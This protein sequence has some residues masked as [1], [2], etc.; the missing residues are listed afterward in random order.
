VGWILVGEVRVKGEGEEGRIWLM[1]FTYLHV[2]LTMKPVEIVLRG[3][4]R[5]G[6]S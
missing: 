3:G 2:N 6:V 1:Y 4:V 5:V